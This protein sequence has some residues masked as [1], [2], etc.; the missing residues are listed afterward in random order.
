MTSATFVHLRNCSE[1]SLSHGVLRIK[2]M[3]SQ[4]A[5]QGMAAVALTDQVNLYG[6]VKFQKAAFGKGV[7]PIFGADMFLLD[8]AEPGNFFSITLLVQNAEGYHNLTELIS[9]A[10]LQGQ[11]HGIAS[12]QAEW[13]AEY[14]N[15]LIMLSGGLYGDVGGALAVDKNDLAVRRAKHWQSVFGAR[16]KGGEQRRARPGAVGHCSARPPGAGCLAVTDNGG[17]RPR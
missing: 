2:P 5:E 10:Y 16:D 3:V 12:I 7:K 9:R 11:S 17:A 6:L 1:F 13:L 4:V 15:G 8:D 14:S